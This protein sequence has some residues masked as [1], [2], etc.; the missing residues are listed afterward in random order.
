MTP[1][2]VASTGELLTAFDTTTN[3]QGLMWITDQVP[4]NSLI[5]VIPSVTTATLSGTYFSNFVFPSSDPVRETMNITYNATNTQWGQPSSQN[6]LEN[7]VANGSNFPLSLVQSLCYDIN[8]HQ[9]FSGSNP[10]APIP[11]FMGSAFGIFELEHA[12][13]GITTHSIIGFR[14]LGGNMITVIRDGLDPLSNVS[15]YNVGFTNLFAVLS[16][17]PPDSGFT[18]SRTP[19]SGI[20][21][22]YNAIT[23]SGGGFDNFAMTTNNI[24]MNFPNPSKPAADRTLTFTADLVGDQVTGNSQTHV[25]SKF[26]FQ[27]TGVTD[28]PYH[29]P[30]IGPGTF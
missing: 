2:G 23:K 14:F 27:M 13:G 29:S 28:V 7:S 20:N 19:L 15:L 9:D 4:I 30:W 16:G 24:T 10:G 18:P 1:L 11:S 3:K 8:S 21:Q 26:T 17:M 5:G 22:F 25:D 6:G 12:T